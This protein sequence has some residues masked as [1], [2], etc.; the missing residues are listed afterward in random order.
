MTILFYVCVMPMMADDAENIALPP[1]GGIRLYR[2]RG[3]KVK[4]CMM[5][6]RKFNM[7]SDCCPPFIYILYLYVL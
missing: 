7:L 4:Y 2:P 5:D 1:C 3:S 6:R